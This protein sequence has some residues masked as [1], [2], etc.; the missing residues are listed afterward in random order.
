MKNFPKI[1]EV[2]E[3]SR[4]IVMSVFLAIVLAVVYMMISMGSEKIESS[5]NDVCSIPAHP[6]NW[7]TKYCGYVVSSDDEIMIQESKCFLE[8]K[9]DED[10]IGS[11]CGIKL[12][13]KE[14]I[15]KILLEYET[16]GSLHACIDDPEV[17]PYFGGK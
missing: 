16:H 15:C 3:L 6:I 2:T 1:V 7:R 11:E 8:A 4:L 14:K 10:E 13:Y 17:K 9:V 12:L 5:R